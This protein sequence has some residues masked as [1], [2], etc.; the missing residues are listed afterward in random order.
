MISFIVPIHE[1]N[2]VTS[3]CVMN[4][5]SQLSGN[6]LVIVADQCTVPAINCT[7]VQTPKRLHAAGSRNLGAKYAINDIMVFVDSD[8]LV[9]AG[10]VQHCE[11]TYKADQTEIFCFPS[12]R[13]VTESVT[14]GFKGML[15]MYSTHYVYDTP[16]DV[17]SQLQGYCCVITKDL[18]LKTGGWVETRTME[19]ESYAT[20]IKESGVKIILENTIQVQ[21]H[22]HKGLALFTTVF[23]R[24]SVWTQ[25][26]LLDKVTWDGKHKDKK[27]AIGSL[28]S[29]LLWPCLAEPML[30]LAWLVA[31][32]ILHAKWL[33]FLFTHNNF[34]RYLS[35]AG[36][37]VLYLNCIGL[38][39][40]S[41]WL[42]AKFKSSK[43]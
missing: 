1:W 5:K 23:D 15:E 24:A 14:A 42:T 17:S 16:R 26:K 33:S 9:P 35:Y 12:G 28:F 8:I 21:H 31:H 37:H 36:I 38:G 10:F 22:N 39:A 32:K 7:V 29:L 40:I 41:G 43:I 4:L 34:F 30:L 11:D 20:K 18:L 27:N 6:E 25:F 3:R 19:L 2:D 13:E